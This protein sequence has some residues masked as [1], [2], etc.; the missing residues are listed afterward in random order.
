MNLVFSDHTWEERLH[1]WSTES[2]ILRRMNRIIGEC[3]ATHVE[4]LENPFAYEAVSRLG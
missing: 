1:R 2:K 3:G 4:E